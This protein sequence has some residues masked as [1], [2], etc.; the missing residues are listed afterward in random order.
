MT[1]LNSLVAIQQW[2]G[3]DFSVIFN[4]FYGIPIAIAHTVTMN[5]GLA[6]ASGVFSSSSPSTITQ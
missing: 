5:M 3:I 6:L 2:K 1:R 4:R